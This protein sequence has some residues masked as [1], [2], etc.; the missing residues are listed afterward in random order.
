MIYRVLLK[1]GLCH[2]NFLFLGSCWLLKLN[3]YWSHINSLLNSIF[4]AFHKHIIKKLSLPELKMYE[5]SSVFLRHL[6]NCLKLELLLFSF[7]CKSKN[8]L[9]Y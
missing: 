4:K 1:M 8:I 2:I 3:I 5:V 6:R 9:I 7:V